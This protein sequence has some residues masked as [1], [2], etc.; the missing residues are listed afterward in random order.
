M[1]SGGG[2]VIDDESLN[3]LVDGELGAAEAGWLARAV[4]C[5]PRLAV[6]LAAYRA[7][8][9]ALRQLFEGITEEPIPARLIALLR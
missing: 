2:K 1:G 6:R 5:D 3:A 7:Q 4:A 9:D 8:G